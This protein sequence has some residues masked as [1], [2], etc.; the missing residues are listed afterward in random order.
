MKVNK[1]EKE[2]VKVNKTEKES[3]K[4]NKTEKDE[5]ISEKVI[6]SKVGSEKLE[7]IEKKEIKNSEPGKKLATSATKKGITSYFI[8]TKIQNTFL[9][10]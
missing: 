1:T 5:K 8:S 3:V 4:V 9:K 2:S 7:T 10:N 6:A